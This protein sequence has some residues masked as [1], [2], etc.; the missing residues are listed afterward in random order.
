MWHTDVVAPIL[1]KW[2]FYFLWTVLFSSLN[3]NGFVFYLV[4]TETYFELGGKL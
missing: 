1:T 4:G 3:Q 2:F